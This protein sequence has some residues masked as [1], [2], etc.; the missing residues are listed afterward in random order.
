MPRKLS[1]GIEQLR[2]LCIIGL[3]PEERI[4]PQPILVSLRV[5]VVDTD[6]FVDYTKLADIAT[7]LA[8]ESQFF[9]L[10]EYASALCREILKNPLIDTL[11]V[12]IEKPKAL[13][14]TQSAFIEM[15]VSK[16]HGP[17]LQDRPNDLA[18]ALP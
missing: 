13:I 1:V 10:E 5:E 11:K 2:I 6:A 8:K 15:E 17:S 14:F 9:L 4:I 12:R 7:H 18:P 16:C 3:L